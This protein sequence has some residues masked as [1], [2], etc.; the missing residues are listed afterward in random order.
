MDLREAR[1]R[2]RISQWELA[3]RTG[4]FQSRIS[5]IENDHPAKAEEK[6]RLAGA[7]ELEP[8]QISWPGEECTSAAQT[9]L[10]LCEAGDE[11]YR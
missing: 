3:K 11:N 2:R 5:L 8:N 10:K 6:V 4:V 1:F 7:L 9:S